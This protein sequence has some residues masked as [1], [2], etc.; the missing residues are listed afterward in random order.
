MNEISCDMCMDLM[1]LVNDGVASG[2]SREAVEHHIKGCDACRKFYEMQEEMT[3]GD[4]EKALSIAVRRVKQ[5]SAAVLVLLVFMGIC[6]CEL[7]FQGSSVAFLVVVLIIRWL[8]LVA[9]GDGRGWKSWLKRGTAVFFALALIVGL[10]TLGNALIGNPISKK[11]AETAAEAYL[12]G[13]FPESDLY[14]ADIWHDSKQGEYE[15]EIQSSSSQDTYFTIIVRPDGSVR[16]DT[17]DNVLTGRNTAERIG[18]AYRQVAEQAVQR[19][20]LTYKRAYISCDLEFEHR[21]WKDDPYEFQY[22]LN[23]E[24]LIPDGAYDVEML[25]ALAGKVSVTVENTEVSAERAADILQEIRQLMDEAGV[26]FHSVDLTLEYPRPENAMDPRK[27]GQ[28][29]IEGFFYEDIYE[30]GLVSRVRE[31]DLNAGG[32]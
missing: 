17:F 10:L 18:E 2:D 8:F 19:L 22:F 21:Q 29:R 25:G 6:L 3:Q 32:A 20:N 7:V 30:D 31:A 26:P 16:F 28:I 23:G 24:A 27:E 13:K 14:I 9:A 12:E 15:M 5:A 11:L 1:P 4:E